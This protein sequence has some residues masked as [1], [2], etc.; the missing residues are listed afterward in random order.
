M[1][2]Q[3]YPNDAV[4]LAANKNHKYL[5]ADGLELN[6]G[7]KVY[8]L[9]KIEG[10]ARPILRTYDV[11]GRLSDGRVHVKGTIKV[12]TTTHTSELK[13]APHTIY[14]NPIPLIRQRLIDVRYQLDV[15]LPQVKS[16]LEEILIS[17]GDTVDIEVGQGLSNEEEI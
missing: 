10:L 12:E 1:S 11:L 16:G 3:A 9:T 7:D 13:I 14:K 6:V 17:L 15:E 8:Q 2:Q 4:F 5:S